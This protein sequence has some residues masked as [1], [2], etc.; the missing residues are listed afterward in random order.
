MLAENSIVD[1]QANFLLC[2]YKEYLFY[3]IEQVTSSFLSVVGSLAR[4]SGMRS[5]SCWFGHSVSIGQLKT[6]LKPSVPSLREWLNNRYI[7]AGG[8]TADVFDQ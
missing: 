7:L 5:G 1:C 4:R 6:C 2:Q 8:M 3:I